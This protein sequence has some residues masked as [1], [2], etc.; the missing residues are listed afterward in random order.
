MFIQTL[1][2]RMTRVFELRVLVLC[3]ITVRNLDMYLGKANVSYIYFFIEDYIAIAKFNK[4][5][6]FL[7]CGK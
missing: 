7:L 1:Y 4:I 3:D 5:V 6:I 2:V